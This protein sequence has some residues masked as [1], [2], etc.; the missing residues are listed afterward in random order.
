MQPLNE[1]VWASWH[2]QGWWTGDNQIKDTLFLTTEATWV[3][4]DPWQTTTTNQ[5][6]LQRTG[7]Y[8]H[9][10]PPPQPALWVWGRWPDL[11]GYRRGNTC[12]RSRLFSNQLQVSV[13]QLVVRHV[14]CDQVKAE[15]ECCVL[16][17][18]RVFGSVGTS[19]SRDTWAALSNC[20]PNWG[21]CCSWVFTRLGPGNWQPAFAVWPDARAASGG[22][23]LGGQG[24]ILFGLSFLW[25]RRQPGRGNLC[26]SVCGGWGR[27]WQEEAGSGKE[28]G[29]YF[30]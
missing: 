20:S 24:H 16:G 21:F 9:A 8:S 18:L 22:S 30:S 19:R 3:T 2:E 26:M 23:W 12:L 7:F 6:N 13:G 28:A 15:E 5:W 4:L 17:G 10:Q 25:T 1:N 14:C 11:S 29:G 27:V